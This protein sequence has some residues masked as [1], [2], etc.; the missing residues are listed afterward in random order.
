MNFI[1]ALLSVSQGRLEGGLNY[2]NTLIA[3]TFLA[4]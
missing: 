2:D 4:F 1:S 3:V